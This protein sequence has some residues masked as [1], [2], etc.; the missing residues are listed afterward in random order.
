MT[1]SEKRGFV[2]NAFAFVLNGSCEPE[3]AESNQLVEIKRSAN[4]N[5]KKKTIMFL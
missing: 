2:L 5:S 1:F 3:R 4:K